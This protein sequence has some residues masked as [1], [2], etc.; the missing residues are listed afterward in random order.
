MT[1]SERDP[2]LRELLQLIATHKE[3]FKSGTPQAQ[4]ID[5]L[6]DELTPLS[7][8]PNAID[9]PEVFRGHWS[10]DYHNIGR[11]VGGPQAKDEG[12][13]VTVSLKVFSMGRLPDIPAKFLGNGLEIVPETGAYNFVS[14]FL[15]GERQVPTHHFSF[16]RYQRRPENLRRFHVEFTGFKVVPADPEMSLESFAREIGVDDP[17]LLAHEL[18]PTTKLWSEVVYMDDDVRVQLGQLGGH[19]VMMRTDRPLYSIE[20]WN[21][22]SVAPAA[23]L[24]SRG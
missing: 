18:D 13:G 24:F 10:A 5:A 2:L 9:H 23:Q 7:K 1:M 8:Y 16:A 14:Q 3:G 15:L 11:L 20:Y 6:I 19:Y 17:A 21:D 12:V 4:R 22:K